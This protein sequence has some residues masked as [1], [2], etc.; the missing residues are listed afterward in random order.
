MEGR[1]C[2]W[3]CNHHDCGAI[4][5]NTPIE[6][7]RNIDLSVVCGVE[8]PNCEYVCKGILEYDNNNKKIIELEEVQL[9]YEIKGGGWEWKYYL[10]NIFDIAGNEITS[11]EPQNL[12]LEWYYSQ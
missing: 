5:F 11:N 8:N 2:F 3:Y 12:L 1:Y 6:F 7:G 9:D 4:I 10:D